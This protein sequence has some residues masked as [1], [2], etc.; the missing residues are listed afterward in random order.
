MYSQ[1]GNAENRSSAD[2]VRKA[3]L[4]FQNAAGCFKHLQDVIVSEMR[5]PPTLDLT[6]PALNVLINLMLAQAQECFWQK[7][8][9]DQLKDGTIA[10]LATKV[11]DFYDV[12][13]DLA[14]NS[15]V[16]GL[17][18]QSWLVQTQVKA[19]HFSGVAHYRKSCEC[20]SQNHYGEEI[21]RLQAAAD[22]VRRALEFRGVKDSVI[23]DLRSL[24]AVISK[25]LTRAEKDN[26]IIYL[27]PVP[28]VSS[29]SAIP[30]TEMV[31]PAPTTEI[32]DPISLMA[33]NER[34]SG[35]LPHPIMGL[36][37][38]QKLVPFAV[39]QA[40]SVF[41]DRKERLVK[42]EIVARW[43]ELTTLCY[44]TLQ[45]LNLPGALQALEQ[46]IGLPPSLL[47]RSEEVQHEGGLH[48]LYDMLENVKSMS[49]R[50]AEIL[51]EALNALD[52]EQEDDEQMR[53]QFRDRWVR[54]PSQALTSQLVEQAQKQRE[55][56]DNALKAD[57]IVRGKIDTWSAIIEVLS[58]P[59]EEL[60][61]SV[62]SA[63]NVRGEVLGMGDD[64][65]AP[66]KA[67]ELIG[68]LKAMLE[69]VDGMIRERKDRVEEVRRVSEADD[70]S[71]ALLHQA[72]LLTSNSPT[73]KIEPAQFEDL[74]TTHLQKY[75]DFRKI[76]MLDEARQEKLLQ[77]ITE[78]NTEFVRSRRNNAVI[79]K[80]EKALQN[81]EQGYLKFKEVRTNL[82][83]GMK[84]YAEFEKSLLRLR[85]NCFDYCFARKV[86]SKDYL[87]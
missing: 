82:L 75:E 37:L 38:F 31:K 22:A 34:S 63:N 61:R 40:A 42:E 60:E 32:I 41:V 87:K 66:S 29:L 85:D 86:E 18:P 27:E 70:I 16:Q 71:P 6:N 51:D 48:A 26:D 30:R 9:M 83:E 65:E 69:R 62:P 64:G 39:H 49:M 2:G 47:A 15:T 80:R 20:I 21:A 11:S 55:T 57:Q 8:V 13:Y 17:F 35:A 56:L 12:A 3:C 74:F 76:V 44:T 1:L 78:T 43:D 23:A 54:P 4:Y 33:S 67:E 58:L 24:Q 53:G 46:P 45:S 7:A 14:T 59:R 50:N 10:R 5:I 52:E 79:A 28:A 81:L 68:R 73:V 84:F 72:A 77:E 19:L 36:P 25:S